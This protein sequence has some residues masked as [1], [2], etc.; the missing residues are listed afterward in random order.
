MQDIIKK[1]LDEALTEKY[2]SELMECEDVEYA[3]SAGFNSEM[4]ALI[5]KTDNKLIYYSRYIAVAACAVLAIGCAVLLPSLLEDDIDVAPPDTTTSVIETTAATSTSI[6]EESKPDFEDDSAAADVDT[7]TITTPDVT[8]TVSETAATTTVTTTTTTTVTTTPEASSTD[9]VTSILD[10]DDRNPGFGDDSDDIV[11]GDEPN[12]GFGGDSDDVV[13]DDEVDDSEDIADD[14]DDDIMG[15][16]SGDTGNN[17]DIIVD[18]EDDADIAE[19]DTGCDDDA[20][21]EDDGDDDAVIEDDEADVEEDADYDTDCDDDVVIDEGDDDAN[22]STG[23]IGPNANQIIAGSTMEELIENAFHGFDFDKLVLNYVGCPDGSVVTDT[24]ILEYNFVREYIM[25]LK[26]RAPTYE[27]EYIDAAGTPIYVDM[28]MTDCT[29]IGPFSDNSP[30]NRYDAIFG[31]S[32]EVDD[33]DIDAEEDY[34]EASV[35]FAIY[36]YG[37]VFVSGYDGKTAKFMAGSAA[38]KELFERI[39]DLS[40]NKNAKTVGDIVSRENLMA[41]DSISVGKAS[42]YR[43]YDLMLANAKLDTEQEKLAFA[44]ILA[45]YCDKEC[46]AISDAP[47]EYSNHI[48]NVTFGVNSTQQLLRL[49]V[50]EEGSAVITDNKKAYRFDFADEDLREL[51]E[52]VCRSENLKKPVF[53]ETL[54]DY[55]GDK[56]GYTGFVPSSFTSGIGSS[57]AIYQVSD[58]TALAE[59]FKMVSKEAKNAEYMPFNKQVTVKKAVFSTGNW[60]IEIR[61]KDYISVNSNYFKASDGF[62]DKIMAYLDKNAVKVTEDYD[63]TDSD[64]VEIEDEL[65]IDD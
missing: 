39:N 47:S 52:L 23:G 45:K 10:D 44:E 37:E 11:V 51:L 43:M 6:P 32:E 56:A 26:D 16:I 15:E 12:P 28:S 13:A 55:L 46:T 61:D 24:S 31:G 17:S 27:H 22:P 19:D 42:V 41:A 2:Y 48:V 49:S 59:L 54:D 53:Y 3:F 64:D 1:A 65:A 34:D 4:K 7:T 50:F 57:S 5:R 60:N 33:D 36:P 18:E 9:D 62:T 21:I 63:E 40:I 38:T 8:T 25:V 58:E 30:R 20:V 14:E 35:E 29:N